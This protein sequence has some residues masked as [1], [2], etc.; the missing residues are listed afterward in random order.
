M[1]IRVGNLSGGELECYID[2]FNLSVYRELQVFVCIKDSKI[3]IYLKDRRLHLL[4][5][6][7]RGAVQDSFSNGQS[8]TVMYNITS[9]VR[10]CGLCD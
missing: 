7:V 4:A 5:T 10:T 1:L 3:Y 6:S 9:L 2:T 8:K